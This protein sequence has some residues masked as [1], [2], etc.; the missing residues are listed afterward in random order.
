MRVHIGM[1]VF[2]VV[3]L[4]FLAYPSQWLYQDS[5]Q[6]SFAKNFGQMILGF[7]PF[8]IL[9]TVLAV[10][11]WRKSELSRKVSEIVFA[12]MCL[13]FPVGTF[14]ALFFFLPRTVWEQKS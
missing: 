13:G 2:F 3:L 9:H 7:A 5:T 1:T 4:A 11:A 12:I 10:G 6:S 14:L 8:I